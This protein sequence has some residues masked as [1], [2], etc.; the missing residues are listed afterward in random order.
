MIEFEKVMKVVFI[1]VVAIGLSALLAAGFHGCKK[2]PPQVDAP[3]E[4]VAV[5][6]PE[7]QKD[8]S[9]GKENSC[10]DYTSVKVMSSQGTYYTDCEVTF[11]ASVTVNLK[12]GKRVWIGENFTIEEQ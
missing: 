5:P 6:Q 3:R 10:G 8:S 4:H 2:K 12:D 11:N 7:P 1:G 9:E